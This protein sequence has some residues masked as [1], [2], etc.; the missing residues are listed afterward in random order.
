MARLFGPLMPMLRT[1]QG[2]LTFDVDHQI[3]SASFDDT[4]LAALSGIALKSFC[5]LWRQ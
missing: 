5:H 1:A 2:N 4:P 3:L